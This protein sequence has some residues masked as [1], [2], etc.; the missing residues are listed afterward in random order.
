MQEQVSSIDIA[1]T[2]LAAVGIEAPAGYS[3]RALQN[4]AH[5]GDRYVLIQHPFIQQTRAETHPHV[6]SVIRSVAGQPVS[7][8]IVENERVGIVGADWKLLRTDDISALYQRSV[9]PGE[10][11]DVASEKTEVLSELE[12]VLERA[13]ADHPLVLIDP[14]EINVELRETL[15]AL[16]YLD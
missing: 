6:N 16:G 12:A 11:R 3:G 14:G 13:L 8:I 9:D 1:P 5:F 2:L 7:E 4:A 10:K 15:E